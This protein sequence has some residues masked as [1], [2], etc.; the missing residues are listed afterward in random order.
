MY[1]LA[2]KPTPNGSKTWML[3]LLEDKISRALQ[4]V[5]AEKDFMNGIP[6]ARELSPTPDKKDLIKV[7]TFCPARDNL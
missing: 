1:A 5:R 4:D 6:F 7:K 2:Q 3:K